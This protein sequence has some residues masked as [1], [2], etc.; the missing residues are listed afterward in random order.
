M[1]LD[2]VL[3]ATANLDKVKEMADFLRDVP[4]TVLSINDL[5]E[6]PNVIEDQPTLEGNAVK[7]ALEFAKATGFP[8]L[9]DD[10]GLE[11]DALNG[12]PGVYSARYA[13]ENATYHDNVDKLLDNLCDI[14][15]DQRQARF[16]TVMALAF[17][18]SVETVEGICE[19]TILNTR[20]GAGG[21]GYDPVFFLPELNKTFAEMNLTEKNKVSH[22]GK[23]LQKMKKVLQQKLGA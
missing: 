1:K 6:F 12:A 4:V 9:A 16:R 11:V 14:P 3:L 23:A 17:N 19:G 5:D 7:K 13:G 8:S 2:R 20:R 10:T 21:F 18:D 15:A 22:R